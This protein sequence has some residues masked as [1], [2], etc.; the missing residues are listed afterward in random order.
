[1][2]FDYGSIQS[3][4][5]AQIADKGQDVIIKRLTSG[6][7][8]PATGAISGAS[9]ASQAI[10]AVVVDYKDYQIDGDAIRRGDK[11]LLID[12]D[13]LPDM[14]DAIELDSLDYQIV[15]ISPVSPSNVVM[16]YKVQVRR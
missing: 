9:T 2:T 12:A 10:K 6:T 14:K 11:Q 4:A 13:S 7:F 5:T 1:M 3:I 15:S 16:L 8:D